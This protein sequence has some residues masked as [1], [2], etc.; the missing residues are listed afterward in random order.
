MQI[1][2]VRVCWC[3]SRNLD[4]SSLRIT[5]F[6]FFN[7]SI[8]IG[9]TFCTEIFINHYLNRLNFSCNWIGIQQDFGEHMKSTHANNGA[10]FTHWHSGTVEFNTNANCKKFNLID[11]FNKK[12]AF[13][14]M[15]H[16]ENANVIFVIYMLGRRSDAQKYMIDFELK[17]DLRKVKFIETCFSDADDI[18]KIVLDHR[19]VILPK[20]LVASYAKNGQL[21]FRF[22]IKKKETIELEN[23]EKQQHLLTNVYRQTNDTAP[24]FAPK[25]QMKAYQ[26]ESNLLMKA[27]RPNSGFGNRNSQNSTNRP[28]PTNKSIPRNRRDSKK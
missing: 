22:F 1:S 6:F 4:V 23:V 26:S 27:D 21:E 11:A 20:T 19:C 14:F 13:L 2:A 18:A 12:F 3:S 7:I 15:S 16:A 10:F 5:S 9:L 17:N 24:H 8:E 28:I 25:T